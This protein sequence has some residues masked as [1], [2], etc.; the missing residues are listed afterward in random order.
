MC[1]WEEQAM[2]MGPEEVKLLVQAVLGTR[3]EELGCDECLD[4]VGDY[5]E[6]QLEGREP[7]EAL[8]RVEEHLRICPEC[9]EEYEAL[10]DALRAASA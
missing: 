1:D 8:R 10:R 7:S 5:A 4:R 9:H 6:H 2:A 3:E